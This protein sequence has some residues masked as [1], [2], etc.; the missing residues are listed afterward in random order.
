MNDKIKIAVAG[1]GS[2]GNAYSDYVLLY[3]DK[4]EIVACADI[5]PDR[6]ERFGDKF[7][8]APEMR[9]SSAEEML[10]RD[11]LADV[12]FVCTMDRLHYPH[13]MAALD[14]GYHLLLEKPVSP[15]LHECYE[16]ADKAREKGVQV[17]VCHVLRYSNM[18]RKLKEVVDSGVL[19]DIVSIQA[20][21]EVCYWHQAHSFVRGNWSNEKRSSPMILQKCCHDM[22]YLYSLVGKKCVSVSSIGSLKH[23]KASEAPEGAT[24][25]CTA[26]CPHYHTCPYSVDTNYLEWGRRG[27][28]S[29][30]I[31]VVS[32]VPT[33]EALEEALRTG[34]YG[35]CVYHCDN[36]VVDHQ[37]VNVLFEGDVTVTF[38]M[39]AF[40]VDGGRRLHIMGTKAD[41]KCEIDSDTIRVNPYVDRFT[42]HSIIYDVSSEDDAFGHGG[43]DAGIVRDLIFLL[44]GEGGVS[45]SATSVDESIESHIIALAAEES[46]VRGGELIRRDEFVAKN[47]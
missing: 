6:V 14:K 3:P 39:C 32:Q 23:F 38:S 17:L 1:L 41:L 5:L 21:E 18:F 27:V 25:R 28:F 34:P 11:K 40:N 13:A 36:D 26:E 2:R 16:I 10:S 37:I 47:R 43:G 44:R 12:V 15:V 31:D 19:G 35:R 30:P 8:V 24:E 42:D 45:S 4:A 46:R 33:M 20:D 29:W 9:F 7:G 22:D